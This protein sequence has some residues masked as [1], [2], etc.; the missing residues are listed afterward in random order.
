MVIDKMSVLTI[1]L[2]ADLP[3]TASSQAEKQRW[4]NKVD[5]GTK[6]ELQLEEIAYNLMA[7]PLCAQLP[8]NFSR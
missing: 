4:E 6:R 5:K 3:T 1:N 2:P 7:R 8:I